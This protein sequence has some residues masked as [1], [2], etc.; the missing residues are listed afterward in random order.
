MG[1]W[2][3]VGHLKGRESTE[4]GPPWT[5]RSRRRRRGEP[6]QSQP[7]GLDRWRDQEPHP[8]VPGD[9]DAKHG[10]HVRVPRLM[11]LPCKERKAMG[12]GP[13]CQPEFLGIHRNGQSLMDRGP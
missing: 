12:R 2:P 1:P 13:N 11:S 5:S 8:V 3:T 7:L 10:L 4:V 6:S 9:E